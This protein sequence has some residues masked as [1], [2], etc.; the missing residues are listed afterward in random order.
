MTPELSII[1]PVYN[2]GSY[3]HECI[4][5]ILAQT[6]ADFELIIVD[7]GSTDGSAEI[8]DG[9]AAK[10]SRIRVIHKDN[11]GVVSA[12]KAGIQAARGIF[13][14]Y[15]D[16][17]DR[18]NPKM[19]EEMLRY[20]K[21]YNCDMVMCNIEHERRSLPFSAGNT[22]TL[23]SGGYHDRGA[24]EK[25][26]LPAMMYTGKFY[27]FG[28]YP[29]I[30]NK[31]YRREKLLKHQMRVD[32]NIRTGE[33]AACVY[34]YL[35]ESDGFY[36]IEDMSLYRY[37]RSQTQMTAVYD[38]AYFERFKALHSFFSNSALAS[39]PYCGQLDYYYAYMIKNAIGNEL[40]SANHVSIRKRLARLGDIVDFTNEKGFID[41]INISSLGMTHRIYFGLL[42]KKRVLPLMLGVYFIRFI[43]KFFK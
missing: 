9:Y 15:V 16:G 22:R 40:K 35:L 7:D 10:D 18:I 39:S 19:Y 13:A 36:F 6:F 20:M 28:I 32:D 12:R 14:G 2:V 33:D 23:V 24:I 25:Y 27:S 21:R 3:L 30:W 31:L 1:V 26:I 4:D 5:S 17:D 37:R 29:V 43:Q 34:P 42:R 8:C 11:G 38:G 41:R